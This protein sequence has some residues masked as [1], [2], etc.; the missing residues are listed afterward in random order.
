MEMDTLQLSF[1]FYMVLFIKYYT[2]TFFV[3]FLR[4]TGSSFSLH[5]VNALRHTG[6][7][8]GTHLVYTYSNLSSTNYDSSKEIIFKKK[9]IGV[10]K[11][12]NFNKHVNLHAA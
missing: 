6:K 7:V 3:I 12:E 11:V 4:S 10:T 9:N 5:N 1:W 8:K 2:C